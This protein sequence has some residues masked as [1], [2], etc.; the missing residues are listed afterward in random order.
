MVTV[1]L[2]Q[3]R[4]GA[5]LIGAQFAF[6]AAEAAALASAIEHAT[7]QANADEDLEG[8]AVHVDVGLRVRASLGCIEVELADE[9]VGAPLSSRL[10]FFPELARQF[11][12]ELKR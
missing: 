1:G 2:A 9:L 3:G 6:V 7:A 12:A 4:L 8:E 11:V 10:V 5:R